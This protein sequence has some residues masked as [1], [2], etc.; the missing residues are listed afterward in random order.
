M[1]ETTISGIIDHTLL[2]ADAR[3]D[4]IIKLAEEAKAYKFASVCVNPAGR[5]CACRAE[6]YTG[7][8]GMYSNRLPARGIDA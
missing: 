8:E 4:D 6:G 2:K 1:S 5:Y 7:S 3:K